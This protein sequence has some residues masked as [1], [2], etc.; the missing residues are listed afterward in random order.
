MGYGIGTDHVDVSIATSDRT[1][2]QGFLTDLN[3]ALGALIKAGCS[4]FKVQIHENGAVVTGN[5]P[6]APR[7][8]TGD[9]RIRPL[10]EILERR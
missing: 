1:D 5:Q 10:K 8:V 6:V 7:K 9:D 2:F 4:E 3:E